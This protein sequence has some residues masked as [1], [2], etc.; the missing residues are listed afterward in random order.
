VESGRGVLDHRSVL[1]VARGQVIYWD[2][3][4]A[5]SV[6]V[7][8]LRD[9]VLFTLPGDRVASGQNCAS[10]DG[11]YFFYIHHDRATFDEI[12]GPPGSPLPARPHRRWLSRGTRLERYDLDTGDLHTVVVINSPI[13]HVN[14]DGPEH[15]IFCHQVSE[16][17][18]L[19]TDYEGGWYTHLRT[20]TPTGGIVCHYCAT[21]RGL[22]YEAYPEGGVVGGIVSPQT[23]RYSEFYLPAGT[24]YTHPAYD[25]RGIR[26]IFERT[27]PASG[28]H[29]LIF[30]LR[31]DPE[32]G[33]A[34]QALT[35][36]WPTYGGG[37]KS[38]FHPRVVLDDRWL[39]VTAGDPR[40]H[41]NHLFLLDIADLPETEGVALPER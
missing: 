10:P 31:H 19:Y 5:H 29:D 16:N 40:T 36:D 24:G 22:V 15:L 18:I 2:G 41:T 13:H 20:Q 14:P 21:R 30:L 8:T 35:G 6:D 4:D 32:H 23:R 9:R 17:S 27:A 28:E 39:L 37:Q 25:P 12:Y 1:N 7:N 26:F 3:N 11:R 33:D 38:H 34:W